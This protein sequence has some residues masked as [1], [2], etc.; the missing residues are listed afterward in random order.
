MNFISPSLQQPLCHSPSLPVFQ[1]L[2]FIAPS[3]LI[4][5]LP[6]VLSLF[7]FLLFV[8]SGVLA[9]ISSFS[10]PFFPFLPFSRALE[11]EAQCSQVR[12]PPLRLSVASV[13][14]HQRRT[15]KWHLRN[16]LVKHPHLCGSP[17]GKFFLPD[18]IVPNSYFLIY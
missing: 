10:H 16:K 4:L 8:F 12:R 11:P 6:L 18:V 17:G 7:V 1:A 13:Q 14:R 9:S 3:G 15:T 2:G 5:S